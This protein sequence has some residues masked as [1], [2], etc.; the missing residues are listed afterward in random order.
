MKKAGKKT[1]VDSS[2][3]AQFFC[4]A[5]R[6][7]AATVTLVPAGQP[8]PRLTPEPKGAPP[9]VS[10]LGIKYARL[11]IKG[12]PASFT[13]GIAD[14]QAESV[15]AA[16]LARNASALYAIHYEFA[17]FWCPSCQRSYCKE[18]YVSFPTFDDGFYDATYGTCPH[19]HR[20]KLDD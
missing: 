9:G 11:S 18:H 14:A 20:R 4:G 19:G 3:S 13:I 15:R 10:K 2:A 5:C 17:P 8:D 7:R 1:E 12:G 6:K 16:L